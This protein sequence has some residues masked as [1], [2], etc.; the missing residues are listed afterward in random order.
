MQYRIEK[1][2]SADT[3][4]AAQHTAGEALAKE[5]LSA[6]LG[7]STEEIVFLR[8]AAGKPYVKGHNI[9]FS[10][11]HSEE[12]VLCAVHEA[13][14]GADVQKITSPRKK[15]MQRV[16][17]AG[18]IA[19]I[20]DDPVRFAEV[21]TRKEA[22][23]KLT[24]KGLGIGLKTIVVADESGLVNINGYRVVTTTDTA[25]VYSIVWKE[26]VSPA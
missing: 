15:V 21:W 26:I 12:H 11:S 3:S 14:I 17:T 1:L 9:H 10:I 19:Y 7:V 20:G 2:H 16:C 25:Y 18:E 23:A 8:T 22:Y 24:G 13:P 5:V 6:A 4:H